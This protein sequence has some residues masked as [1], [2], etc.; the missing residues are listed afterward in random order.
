MLFGNTLDS[1]L[2]L[3]FSF[4][5]WF[6]NRRA[7]WRKHQK[8]LERD[9]SLQQSGI[10]NLLYYQYYTIQR[11]PFLPIC[12]CKIPETDFFYCKSSIQRN[13][14]EI[15]LQL[16]A[17]FLLQPCRLPESKNVHLFSVVTQLPH[18]LSFL[19]CLHYLLLACISM[20]TWNGPDH[21]EVL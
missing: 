18:S 4:K 10:L 21:L 19:T 6:Q 13:H 14:L 9:Q 12:V 16:I 20:V 3:D 17:F 15:G 5:V 1:S 7:K 11:D 2:N 8:L